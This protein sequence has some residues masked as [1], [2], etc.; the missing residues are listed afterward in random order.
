[1]LEIKFGFWLWFY[2]LQ[3]HNWAY[4][5]NF[6]ISGFRLV[7][8]ECMFGY[9]SQK[10][11]Q[12]NFTILIYHINF[13]TRQSGQHISHAKEFTKAKLFFKRFKDL[14]GKLASRR[15]YLFKRLNFVGKWIF[16]GNHYGFS[17]AILLLVIIWK[18]INIPWKCGA[19]NFVVEATK[20]TF[21]TNLPHNG[22]PLY[23]MKNT[24]RNV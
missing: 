10:R 21:I 9:P 5:A 18:A 17:N 23:N 2:S 6:G 7:K 19:H 12:P 14:K 11:T 8:K 22:V 20:R 1:M 4:L 16:V 3:L 24:C 13:G 15:I